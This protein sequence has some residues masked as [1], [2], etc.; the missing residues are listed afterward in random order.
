MRRQCVATLTM[1]LVSTSALPAQDSV[2]WRWSVAGGL[3]RNS[4]PG[5]LFQPS[6][7][8]TFLDRPLITGATRSLGHASL[9]L[10]RSLS[11]TAL[12]IRADLLY[13]R[14][15]SAPR[16]PASYPVLPSPYLGPSLNVRPA[17][18][19]EMIVGTVGFQWDAM[20]RSRFSPYVLTSAGW[21][22]SRL[23]WSEDPY[24]D[25]PDHVE[26]SRAPVYDFGAGLRYQVGRRELFL[27]VRRPRS[28]AY[29]YGANI[30]PLSL[31]LRF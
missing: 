9:G 12:S 4:G 27:E 5:N 17:L 10:S 19:D 22:Y 16:D 13:N 30:L 28:N 14:G 15:E 20:P 3:T 8:T 6:Q 21:T 1:L 25:R 31:G 23:H 29:V 18:I 7:F 11:A 2:R 26:S 24:S